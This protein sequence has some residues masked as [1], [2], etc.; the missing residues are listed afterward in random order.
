MEE[1]V[2][3]GGVTPQAIENFWALWKRGLN[4]T[5][6]AVEP[7]RRNASSTG[8][9]CC[10]SHTTDFMMAFTGGMVS[11]ND[12]SIRSTTYFAF[13]REAVRGICDPDIL[14][15]RS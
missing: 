3:T 2:L 15:A 13:P 5:Y 12:F 8:R 11:F 4:G 10:W 7:M 6:I 1:F 9:C 14:E